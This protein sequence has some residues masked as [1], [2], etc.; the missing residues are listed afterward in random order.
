MARRCWVGVLMAVVVVG[1][2]CSGK[3][4]GPREEF[5]LEIADAGVVLRQVPQGVRVERGA[6]DRVTLVPRRGVGRITISMSEPVAGVVDPLGPARAV[7]EEI[8]GL[9]E[10]RFFGSQELRTPLGRAFTARGRFLLGA[11]MVEQVRV[12]AAHPWGDRFLTASFTYP[13][14]DDTAARVQMLLEV[15]G[16]IEGFPLPVRSDP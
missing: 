16:E 15:F 1:L 14:G 4:R 11:E 10:G 2:G 9:P 13:A 5:S 3:S 8:A 12:V 6:D 7:Q